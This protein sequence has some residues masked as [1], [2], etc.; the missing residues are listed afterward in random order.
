M[1]GP[2]PDFGAVSTNLTD[3]WPDAERGDPRLSAPAGRVNMRNVTANGEDAS[4]VLRPAWPTAS[5]VLDPK[6]QRFKAAFPWIWVKN[7]FSMCPHAKALR[8]ESHA[9]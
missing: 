8:E 1:E 3:W 4:A 7:I 6:S 5:A 9:C 2:G